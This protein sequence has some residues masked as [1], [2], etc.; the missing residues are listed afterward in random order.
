MERQIAMIHACLPTS[1]GSFF[2]HARFL[3][4]TEIAERTKKEARPKVGNCRYLAAGKG[5]RLSFSKIAN[6]RIHFS[7]PDVS[8][9]YEKYL[10]QGQPSKGGNKSVSTALSPQEHERLDMHRNS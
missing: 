7:S 3:G 10:R 5:I 9:V 1:S 4:N 6:D 2:V 8:T